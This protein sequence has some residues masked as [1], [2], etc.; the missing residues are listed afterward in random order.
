M[1]RWSEAG[2]AHID[3]QD[4]TD[5]FSALGYVHGMNRGWTLTLWRQT[6]LGHLSRW[7]GPGVAPFDMHTRRLGLTRQARRT[8]DR[9]PASLKD[10]LRAYTRGLNAALRSSSVRQDAPFV[11][12]DIMPSR[13]APWHTLLIERLMAWLSTP[14]L[15]PP[16]SAPPSVSEFTNTDRQFR[17]WLHLYGWNRSVAWAV[18]SAPNAPMLF[19]RHILGA[20]AMP[21]VQEVSWNRPADTL[22]A[23]TLP[24]TL[25]FPTG[26]TAERAWASLLHSP[27]AF[28]TTPLDSSAF[29][30]WHERLEPANGNEQLVHVRRHKGDLLLSSVPPPSVDS[31]APSDSARAAP[32]AT[33]WTLQWPGFAAGSDLSAWLHRAGMRNRA[34]DSARFQLFSAHGLRVSASGSWSVLGTPPVV[35]RDSVEKTILVGTSP[36]T[37]QQAKSLHAHSLPAD[38]IAVPEWSVSDS[39]VWASD[40]LSHLQPVLRPGPRSIERRQNAKTYLRNWDHSYTPV[41]IGATLFDQWMR[42]YRAELGHVPTLADTAAYFATYR[43]RRALQRALDTLTVRLGPDVQRWRWERAVRDRRYFPVWSADSLVNANLESM[44]TTRYAPLT[45]TGQGHPSALSG[46]ASLVDPPG[47]APSPTTWDGWMRPGGE[48]TVRRHHYDPSVVF[49]RSRMRTERAPP[50]RLSPHNTALT[51]TLVPLK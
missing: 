37:R 42:A 41:S 38:T 45:R 30:V 5:F 7:F 29:R 12:L 10:R 2:V 27:A 19:Q 1:I 40:L 17:R 21:V 34:A 39:S 28:R 9:L 47:I 49:A 6:A 15:D 36:W 14:P 46:G 13:W 18:Q 43:Q 4:T 35:A 44:R 20:T 24:G 48:F 50:V 32:Q 33:A 25:L 51:T 23:A 22:T 16:A 3:T 11:L 31:L 8:Y 26:R